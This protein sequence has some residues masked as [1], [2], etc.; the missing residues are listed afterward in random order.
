[1]ASFP[2]LTGFESTQIHGTGKDVLWGTHHLQRW[3][4][5]LELVR[6]SGVTTLRYPV[7]WHRIEARPGRY[8]WAWMDEVLAYMR[9]A[10]LE[11]IVD[12]IHHTSF[13]EWIKGGFENPRFADLYQAFVGEFARRYPWVRKYTIFNEPFVT[14]LFCGSEGIWYPYARSQRR[15]VRMMV[16]VGRAICGISEM[17]QELVPGVELIHVDT[18][19]HHQAM[20][21]GSREKVEFLNHRRFLFHDLITGRIDEAHPLYAYLRHNGFLKKE[22][23]WFRSHPA[24]IDVLGLDYYSHSEQQRYR[25]R[26]RFYRAPARGFAAVAGDYIERYG[27]PVM[28]SET[29]IKGRVSDRLSW[30]KHMAEE[31]GKVVAA[32]ADFRGF[33]W[34]PFVDSTDWCSL[35]CRAEKKVDAVGIY[36]LD[37]DRWARHASE[38]SDCFGRLARGEM[39]VQALPSYR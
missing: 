10:G 8:D 24:R 33:C 25:N 30:L 11:P 4:H 13:P 22:M 3:R 23:R 36:W 31:C 21:A 27:L 20:D 7:P 12:P 37:D 2:W 19:E 17:L 14:T 28:L 9:E 26:V 39:S 35:V 32:G 18:C 29:N 34:F 6:A 5:D 16:Q 38:L 15:F 1:M